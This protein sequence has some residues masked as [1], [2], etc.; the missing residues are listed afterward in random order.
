MNTIEKSILKSLA[1]I[2]FFLQKK[3]IMNMLTLI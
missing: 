3:K 1:F 2:Y